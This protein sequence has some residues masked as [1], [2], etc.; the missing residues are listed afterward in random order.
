MITSSKWD[1]RFL[2]LAQH[3]AQWSKDPSTKVGAVIVGGRYRITSLGFNG[4]PQDMP[5]AVSKYLDRQEKYSRIIHAEINALLFAGQSVEGHTVY[6]W[7]MFCCD[8]CTVQLIQAGIY[9]FVAPYP[10]KRQLDRW[11]ESIERAKG[12]VLDCHRVFQEYDMSDR[13]EYQFGPVS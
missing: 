9:R 1:L 2:K 6:T 13:D 3:V 4:F 11:G 12:Y 8:R 10:T 7:P 5:D